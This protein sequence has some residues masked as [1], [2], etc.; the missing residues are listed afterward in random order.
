M[1]TVTARDP[2]TKARVGR[3]IGALKKGIERLDG[4]ACLIAGVDLS[5]IGRRFGQEEGVGEERLKK[6][7]VDD[8]HILDYIA[9][10]DKRGFVRFMKKI[11]PVNNVCGYPALY[12]LLDLLDGRKGEL[13]AYR[14]NVEPDTDSMVSFAALSFP[15]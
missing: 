12:V 1:F 10:G 13:I 3:F 9:S 7:E 14:Q 4:K 11:N 8:K 5:H 15:A 2:E 6:T